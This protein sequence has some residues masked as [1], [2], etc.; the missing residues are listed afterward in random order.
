MGRKKKDDA[1]CR[2]EKERDVFQPW[3]KEE[4]WSVKFYQTTA[5]W[6]HILAK[7]M[8][9]HEVQKQHAMSVPPPLGHPTATSRGGKGRMRV[10]KETR[11]QFASRSEF[12]NYL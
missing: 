8:C 9:G 3:C 6:S 10:M 4:E 12:N 7:G 2:R 5:V 1:K 11:G